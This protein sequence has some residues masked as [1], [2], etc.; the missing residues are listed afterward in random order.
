MKNNQGASAAA[1]LVS[2]TLNLVQAPQEP[3]APAEAPAAPAAVPE[4][5]AAPAEN[6]PAW[7]PPIPS[8]ETV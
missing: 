3:A 2:Q 4:A 6:T 8:A 7:P 1:E 5:P